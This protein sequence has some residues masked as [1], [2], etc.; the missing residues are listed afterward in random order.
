MRRA[1]YLSITQGIVLI[2]FN[3]A[4]FVYDALLKGHRLKAIA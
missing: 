3:S 1:W 2:L 4:R